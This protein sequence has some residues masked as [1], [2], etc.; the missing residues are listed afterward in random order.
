MGIGKSILKTIR[1]ACDAI[2][3]EEPEENPNTES[4]QEIEQKPEQ[5]T[6]PYKR[7]KM[8]EDWALYLFPAESFNIIHKTVG[9]ADLEGRYTEDCVNPDYRFRD[10]KTRT[11]FWVECKFRSRRGEKGILEWTDYKHLQRYKKIREESGIKLYI[12]VGIGGSPDDPKEILFFDLDEMP[13]YSLY[14]SVQNNMRREIR[15]Y[16]SLKELT[17]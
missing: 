8:F 3:D 4:K 1:N 9:G 7:G 13:Y 16:K 12:L 15:P 17:G 10:K 6:D 5:E 11:E 14:Y 2:L